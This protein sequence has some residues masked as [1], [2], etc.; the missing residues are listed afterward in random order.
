MEDVFEAPY[1]SKSLFFFFFLEEKREKEICVSILTKEHK[2]SEQALCH[3][4]KTD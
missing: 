1:L 2:N 3:V 4:R